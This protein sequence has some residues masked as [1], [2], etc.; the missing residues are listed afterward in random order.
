MLT[1]S[2]RAKFEKHILKTQTCWIWIGSKSCGYGVFSSDNGV[3]LRA[4]RVSWEMANG[5]EV[6][7]GLLICHHCD[8]RDCVRPEHLYAGTYADNNVDTYRRSNHPFHKIDRT[9]PHTHCRRGHLFTDESI[10]FNKGRM[11]RK[12]AICAREKERERYKRLR[13]EPGVW[14]GNKWILHRQG[15]EG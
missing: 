2:E 7:P 15:M 4:H 5:C 10:Y 6:P 9:L 13:R 11:E 3:R 1:D 14:V 12:C 8:V